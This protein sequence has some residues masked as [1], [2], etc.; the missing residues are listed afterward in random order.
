MLWPLVEMERNLSAAQKKQKLQDSS[1]HVYFCHEPWKTQMTSIRLL[2]CHF[3]L[4]PRYLN[5][6]KCP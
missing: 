1:L 5:G 3:D 2:L 4:V 6:K